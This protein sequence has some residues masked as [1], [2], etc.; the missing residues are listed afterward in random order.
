MGL[1]LSGKEMMASATHSIPVNTYMAD[2]AVPFGNP[3][4]SGAVQT[5]IAESIQVM[6]FSA[7]NP[8]YHGLLGRDV[9]SRGFFSMAAFDNRFTI[10]M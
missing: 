7:K 4:A 9:L 6:E 10:C 2:I 3:N 1:V 8:A 5:V